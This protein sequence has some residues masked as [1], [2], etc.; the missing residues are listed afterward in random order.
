MV[1]GRCESEP[2][3]G[4]LRALVGR[5]RPLFA[6]IEILDQLDIGVYISR[7]MKDRPQADLLVAIVEETE[8]DGLF[9]PAEE[10]QKQ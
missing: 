7:R 10:Q 5:T 2:S 1:D 4:F 3:G 8:D 6:G 9:P